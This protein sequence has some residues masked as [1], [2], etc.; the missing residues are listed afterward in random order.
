MKLHS[1]E[2]QVCNFVC[3][4][5]P[6][7]SLTTGAQL[8]LLPPSCQAQSSEPV[9]RYRSTSRFVI[10]PLNVGGDYPASPIVTSSVELARTTVKLYSETRCRCAILLPVHPISLLRRFHRA[11]RFPHF[12]SLRRSHSCARDG[13]VCNNLKWINDLN[14]R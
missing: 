2:K 9:H 8:S 5:F 6:A 10:L 7:L 1:R 13:F 14:P 12:V 3:A 11:T 4:N